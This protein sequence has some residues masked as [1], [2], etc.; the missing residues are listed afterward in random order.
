MKLGTIEVL[1]HLHHTAEFFQ[2]FAELFKFDS[3]PRRTLSSVAPIMRGLDQVAHLSLLREQRNWRQHHGVG[4]LRVGVEKYGKHLV[5]LN[6]DR[7]EVWQLADHLVL[8]ESHWSGDTLASK[9]PIEALAHTVL[10]HAMADFGPS[11]R[12]TVTSHGLVADSEVAPEHAVP[13]VEK[14][15]AQLERELLVSHRSALLHGPAGAGKTAASR[16]IAEA[17]AKTTIVVSSE[18]WGGIRS[19]GEHDIFDMLCTWRPDCVIF[20]D[21]DRAIQ[22]G[23]EGYLVGGVSRVRAVVPLVI[24]TANV[25]DEFTGSL[26]RPGRVADRLVRFDKLDAAVA[27]AS[28]PNVPDNIRAAAIEL[29]LLAAYLRELN[30]RCLAGTDDPAAALIEMIERQAGAGDGLASIASGTA[31]GDAL[32]LAVLNRPADDLLAEVCSHEPSPS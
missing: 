19:S 27:I 18:L 14:L 23:D 1:S 11:A 28:T 10:T 30:I 15:C 25:R 7:V 2:G 16:Q 8:W 12:A 21:L 17:L 5:S 32:E 6:N 22:C 13:A 29:G 20:D 9:S 26:L 31:G 4:P 24:T 3:L